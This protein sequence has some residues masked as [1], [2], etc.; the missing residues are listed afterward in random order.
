MPTNF[1]LTA[2]AESVAAASGKTWEDLS[3]QVLYAP[4]GMTSTSSRFSDFEKRPDRAFGHVK[5]GDAFEPKYQRQPD[6]Q[7][8]AGGVSSSVNDL[9]RWMA[10]VLQNGDFGGQPIIAADALLP[11]IR[12]EIISAPSYAP[13]ARPGF[14]GYGFGVG[15]TPSGRTLITHSGAFALGAGTYY[16]LLP[17]AD[18]GIVVL[19]NA[20]PT[21][22][23]EA[24]GASFMDLVQFGAVTEDWFALYS[25]RFNAMLAPVGD[26][27]GKEKPDHPAAPAALASY[28]GV[29]A[30]PYFG[31]AAI[32]VAGDHLELSIGPAGKTYPLTRWD[33]DIFAI[34]P[35]S[36]NEPDG[37]L[38]SV[39]FGPG[40]DMK[41]A[42]LDRDGLGMFVRR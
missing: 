2:A 33:G 4:L 11:A 5:V 3:E 13:D 16:G 34:S 40:G 27:T 23:A 35:S 17:S 8:P 37:S 9:A 18:V 20:W 1:G 21:G 15:I 32:A 24:I 19:T 12:A 36:E 14:Y 7:S 6:A 25:A 31:D 42:Y 41:I 30:N 22:T 38:S 29:Y 39:T 28:A 10:M 26:L